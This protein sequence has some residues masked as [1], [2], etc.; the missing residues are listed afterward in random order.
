SLQTNVDLEYDLP[1]E[2]LKLNDLYSHFFNNQLQDKFEY[3][4]D[5]YTYNREEDTYEITGGKENRYRSRRNRHITNN[6]IR[7][8][9]NYNTDFG[10]HSIK[11]MAGGEAEN[12]LDKNFE[13]IAAPATNYIDLIREFNELQ[14][15][16]DAILES[17]RAGFIGRF[18][19][20]YQE[21]H[22]IDLV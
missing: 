9:L 20:Y 10:D 18:N 2:G 8:L 21:K 15:V 6:V 7:L 22:L 14:N 11:A 19:Y 13:I 5:T 1:V 4:F 16:N 12:K 17:A 3:S